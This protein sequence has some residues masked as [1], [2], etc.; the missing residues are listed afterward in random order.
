MHP[1]SWGHRTDGSRHFVQL[2]AILLASGKLMA[3]IF[4]FKT[5]NTSLF[6]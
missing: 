4:F 6:Q 1:L 5:T 3:R 2:D